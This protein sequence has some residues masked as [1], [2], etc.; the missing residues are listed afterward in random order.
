MTQSTHSL[1]V[2][3]MRLACTSLPRLQAQRPRC[4][5]RARA[6]SQPLLTVAP[7]LLLAAAGPS[8]ATQLSPGLETIVQS[9]EGLEAVLPKA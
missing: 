6:T 8:S 1:T 3:A 5:A 4:I 7:A 2:L 9:V